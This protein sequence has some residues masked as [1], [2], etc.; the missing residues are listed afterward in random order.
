MTYAIHKP[1]PPLNRYVECLWYVN[2]RAPYTREKILPSATHELIINFGAPF[3][4]YD[5]DDSGRFALQVDSWLVGLQTTYLLNALPDE[6]HMVGVRFKPGG[7]YPFLPLP[8]Y[9]LHNQVVPADALWG[10]FIVEARERL[11]EAPTLQARFSL[12][13]QLLLA[14][15]RE[16]PDAMDIVQFA[17]AQI[18]R[19]NGILSVKDLSDHIGISQKHLIT[20]F[21]RIIGVSPKTLARVYRFQ[22]VLNSIDPA[23]PLDWTAIAHAAHYYDQSHFNKDFAAF[24][25]LSPND[26]VRLRVEVF[27]DLAQ[28][29]NIHFVPVG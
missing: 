13:E 1:S 15:L 24:T 6:T 27:G 20:H 11:Y 22:H 7:V 25:G 9:E 29:E 28:G 17:T 16:P 4:L 8:A 5:H 3:R 23:K 10:R 2:L 19:C 14:R 21:Q 26:Y 18:A 12:L